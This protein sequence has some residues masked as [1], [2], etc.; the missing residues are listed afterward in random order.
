MALTD[1]NGGG[2]PAT[3]LVGP[4]TMG[5]GSVPYAVPMYGGQGGGNGGFG[6]DGGW[7]IVLL[8]IVIAALGGGWGGNNN[9][10]NGGYGNAPI[11]V[12]D[13]NGGNVQRGFDQAAVMAGLNGIQGG[14]SGLS[15]QLCNCCGDMQMS[16]A[17]GFAGVNSAI[18]N[19]FSQAEIA[20]NARQIADMQQNFAAQTATMQGFNGVQSQLAQCCCDNRLATNDL[21]YT[22]ATEN[23]ADRAAVAQN[24]RDIIESQNRGTQAILDKLCQL[25]LDGVKGQLAQ[26]Q[27]ENTGLQNQL[28]MAAMRE[29]QTAQNAFIAQGLNNEVDALYNRLRNCPV[30]SMP[31]YGM[32]PIFTCNQNQGCGC[33]CG[34]GN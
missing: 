7:W 34:C 19:G 6:N 18:C 11:I 2:I 29:S 9:G 15:T 33:G 4:A 12:S 32:T 16:V 13:G 8:I 21:K 3:M 24:T 26:A 10:A 1:E 20:N 17:N 23:C 5:G 22:I 31:V 14:I 28:N 27:R 30:P 25:E